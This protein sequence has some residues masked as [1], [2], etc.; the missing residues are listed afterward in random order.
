MGQKE[1]FGTPK[2]GLKVFVE[3]HIEDLVKDR[4]SWQ[5][6]AG[7]LSHPSGI[8][9]NVIHTLESGLRTLGSAK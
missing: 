9:P 2:Q 7:R 8:L 6:R 5:A 3:L 4:L 1:V